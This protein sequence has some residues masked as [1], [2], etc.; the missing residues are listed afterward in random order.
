MM[1]FRVGGLLI[2]A[3]ACGLAFSGCGDKGGKKDEGKAPAADTAKKGGDKA[4]DKSNDKAGEKAAE[5][6]VEKP[7]EKTADKAPAP[8]PTPVAAPAAPPPGDLPPATPALL[9]PEKLNEQAPETFT[10]KFVTTKGDV[11]IDVTRGWSPLGADRF[12][13]MVKSGFYNEIGIFRVV[14]GF[15]AQFGIHGNPQVAG[16]WRMARI[17]DDPRKPD[18]S[19]SR[20]TVVFATA[21]PNTR[22]TQV[23]IN[24]GNNANLDAMGF[25]PFG[26]VKD[27]ASLKVVDAINAEYRQKPAQ[28]LIQVQGNAY[29]KKAFPNLDYIKSASIVK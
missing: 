27:D 20:G 14:P 23:F 9:A 12:Y 3:L 22:T 6:P 17:K 18:I 1:G 24:F 8:A 29:L 11:L 28:G 13:N 5:K 25:T 10:V 21:G 7:A 4:A 15:V 16:K 26:K 2:A 19:N